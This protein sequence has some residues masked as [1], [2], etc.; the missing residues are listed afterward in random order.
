MWSSE[1]DTWEEI[2]DLNHPNLIQCIAAIRRGRQRCLMFH[3]ADGGNLRD[4]W[5]QNSKPNITFE[6]VKD[7]I[8]QL[9]GMAGALEKLHH[10]SGQYHYRHGDIKPE[11][12]LIFPGENKSRIGTFK[13]A[14][15]GSAR[16]HSVAT[17]FRERTSGNMFSTI[18]YQPPESITNRLSASSRLCDIWSMGCVTLELMVWLLYGYEELKEFN[19]RIKG[20]HGEPSA[21]FE[22]VPDQITGQPV[23]Y[24]HP[25]VQNCLVGIS[26]DPEC[27][28]NTALGALL[29][30]VRTKLL[31]VELRPR[32]TEPVE[33]MRDKSLVQYRTD[34]SGLVQ[35][36]NS[37]LEGKDATNE[38]YWFTGGNRDNLRLPR[39]LEHVVPPTSSTLVQDVSTHYPILCLDTSH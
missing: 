15:L 13:I 24:I 23:A 10:Y 31:L 7:V 8:G 6:V 26:T 32:S 35:A 39:S 27:I 33:F 22:V 12:I 18:V 11:N 1:V 3:W 25:V 36:L 28:G 20:K 37:I 17:A 34:S 5:I 38:N 9:R 30:L 14:D 19:E 4:L 21:F 29:D 2:R 16:R